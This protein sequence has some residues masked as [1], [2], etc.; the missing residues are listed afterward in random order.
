MADTP[1]D[2]AAIGG[3]P[4]LRTI[5]EDFV[6]RC[7]DDLMIGYLFPRERREHVKE[8][9]Y[10]HAAEHLGANV[11]YRGRPLEKAHAPHRVKGGQF[12]RRLVILDDVLSAHAVPDAVK[13]RWLEA[14]ASL[15]SKITNQS[16]G[17]CL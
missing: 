2:F 10:Q 16:A 14:N 7:F 11:E 9:E 17:E 5:I 8:F 6:D 15:R 3:E 13:A 4:A 12:D 1:T